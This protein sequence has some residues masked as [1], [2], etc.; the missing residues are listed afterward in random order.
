MTLCSSAAAT[1]GG[2]GQIIY[3]AAN[4]MLDAMAHRLR[5]E[6]LDCNSVQW[7][8][9]TVHFDLDPSGWAKLA[10]T[11]LLPMLP[12][13]ALAVGLTKRRENVVV[14]AFDLDRAQQVLAAYG[15]GPL[16]S[17]LTSPAVTAA[18]RTG[19]QTTDLEQRLTSLLAGAIGVDGV[20][21][22]DT[23]VPM[24]AIG[25]DSL[26]ALE[27]RRRIKV[28]FNHDLEVSELLGGASIADVL[29]RI[30]G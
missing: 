19:V 22:I 1:I 12:A 18:V 3:A 11:G 30:G 28:E 2:R 9:W 17:Q 21:A 13:D 5:S 4:R 23:T 7:G 26:Q 6:G 20:D 25:L 14:A 24:V 29:L 15:Y 8:Q 16:L 10:A 27:F